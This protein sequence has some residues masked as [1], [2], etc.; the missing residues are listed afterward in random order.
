MNILTYESLE[1]ILMIGAFISPV[2]I[3]GKMSDSEKELAF[4]N[5]KTDTFDQLSE[6]FSDEHD[7]D[8]ELV[9]KEMLYIWEN[10][11]GVKDNKT[12]LQKDLWPK[13]FKEIEKLL[14]E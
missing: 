13:F 4:D 10:V 6:A 8:K 11:L 5:S 1:N 2:L 12:H 9:M 14:N 7:M 3:D